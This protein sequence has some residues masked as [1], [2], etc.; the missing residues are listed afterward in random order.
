MMNELL[1]NF[2]RDRKIDSFQKLRFLLFLFQHPK[3]TGT[4][5]Q[6]AERLYLGEVSLLD[7]IINDLCR[8]GLVNCVENRYMLYDEPD[9][10]FCL[11][12]LTQV[13][14][15]PLARQELIEHVKNST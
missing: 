13:F 12:Y 3:L 8:A 9:V 1:V 6:F 5:Q 14:D 2:I 7:K 15:D 4:S 10:R 11:Q